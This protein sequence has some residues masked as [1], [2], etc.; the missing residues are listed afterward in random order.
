MASSE[1]K[2]LSL[3]QKNISNLFA[4]DANELTIN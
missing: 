3:S 1:R 2:K 4:T